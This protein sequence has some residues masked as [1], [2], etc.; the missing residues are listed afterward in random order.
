M[1]WPGYPALAAVR[2]FIVTWGSEQGRGRRVRLRGSAQAYQR[3][4]HRGQPQGPAPV[5]PGNRFGRI[6]A[7]MTAIS[8]P[9]GPACSSRPEGSRP[10]ARAWNTG[11]TKIARAGR[12]AFVRNGVALSTPYAPLTNVRHHKYSRFD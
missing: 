8:V 10:W 5:R 7:D 12:R 6:C 2:E 4:A 11:H 9:G 3:P 1:Q